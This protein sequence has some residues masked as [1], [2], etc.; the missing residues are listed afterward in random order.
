M[1]S[2]QLFLAIPKQTSSTL[3]LD[4][5]KL[6]FRQNLTAAIARSTK[7]DRNLNQNALIAGTSQLEIAVVAI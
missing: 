7:T 3:L 6:F 1:N 5:I 4:P 2:F